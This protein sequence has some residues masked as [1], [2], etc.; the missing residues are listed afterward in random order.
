MIRI[1]I[2]D[3]HAAIRQ[4]LAFMLQR[5]PDMEVTG[6]AASRA[7][8]QPFLD[9]VDVA[10]VDLDLNGRSGVEVIRDLRAVNP[11]ARVLVLSGSTER[12]ELA[13]AVQTGADALLHKSTDIGDIIGAVRQLA[14]GHQL[15]SLREVMDLIA[16]ASREQEQ[17]R[18]ESMALERLTPRERDVLQALAEGLSDKQIAERLQIGIETV[19]THMASLLRKLRVES[20]L[21][22]VML[23]IRHGAVRVSRG[24]QE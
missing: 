4:P 19:R 7:E 22:A 11:P 20:R 16:L 6:Q 1:L 15:L 18:G 2:V 21:Q 13:R 17:R 8:A 10:I 24:G 23:A 5:E 9:D 12:H 14:A 3:D